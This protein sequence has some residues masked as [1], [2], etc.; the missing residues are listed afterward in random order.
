M[1]SEQDPG[2]EPKPTF[3]TP[4]IETVSAEATQHALRLSTQALHIDSDD[5]TVSM[6][7]NKPETAFLQ[8]LLENP[9]QPFLAAHV[10]EAASLAA[11]QNVNDLFKKLHP[12]LDEVGVGTN[13]I[14]YGRSKAT[15]YFFLPDVNQPDE[16]I[17]NGRDIIAE[18]TI[19]PTVRQKREKQFD[20]L[21]RF[22]SRDRSEHFTD[23]K[24]VYRALGASAAC[25]L[26]GG[27]VYYA[28]HRSSPFRQK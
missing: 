9:N 12:R 8:L 19:D 1:T 28:I 23:D 17:A 13:F 24:R 27:S 2:L 7:L 18:T 4:K 16:V 5:G 22:F 11:D 25:L 6:V 15:W 26:F 20:K 14:K 10:L 21:E 3:V